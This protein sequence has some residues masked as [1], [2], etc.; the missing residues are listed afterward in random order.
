MRQRIIVFDVN[1]TLLD[2]RALMP[3]FEKV[4]GD[5]EV[6]SIWFSQVLQTAL[7]TVV[8]GPYSDFGKVGRGALDM[9]AARRGIELTDTDRQAILGGMR[10]LPPHPDVL[11]AIL[12]LKE[13]GF[14]LATLT[15]S[16]PA[17]AQAQ[18]T[19]A[20]IA[21]HLDKMLSVDAV[22]K[23][24]PAAEVYHHAAESFGVPPGQIRLVAAHSWDVAGAM[25]AGCKAAFIARRGMVLDPLF[26]S[27]DIVGPDLSSVG[28]QI[29]TT[30]T[31]TV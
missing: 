11:P 16:P 10:T 7:L 6:L 31:T 29:V 17:V 12:R 1:E 26:E 21:P 30:D 22:R 27:P 9:V 3:Q 19:N 23:L 4:F 20:G 5:G 13:A 8:T 18:L 15:N 25:R 14:R 24:K 28:E 2:L